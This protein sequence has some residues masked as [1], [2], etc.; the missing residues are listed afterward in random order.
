MTERM[1]VMVPTYAVFWLGDLTG[2][3]LIR[4]T[5]A[6]LGVLFARPD[7]LIEEFDLWQRRTQARVSSCTCARQS[8]RRAPQPGPRSPR[9]R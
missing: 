2:V 1:A 3:V 9:D 5:L 8:G 7:I 6:E 4:A